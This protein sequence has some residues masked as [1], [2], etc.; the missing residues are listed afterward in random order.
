MHCV[1]CGRVMHKTKGSYQYTESGVDNVYLKGVTIYKCECG[2]ELPEIPHIEELHRVIAFEIV[3]SAVPLTG[4]ELRFLRKQMAIRAV[5]LA[6]LIGVDEVTVSR[7]EHDTKPVGSNNDRLIRFLFIKKVEEEL[8][9]LIGM[10]FLKSILI[11]LPHKTMKPKEAFE[12]PVFNISVNQLSKY[13]YN[14]ME[15]R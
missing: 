1:D 3:K 8:K 15:C 12:P 13:N 14:L 9:A 5:D 6:A 2:E 4:S 7:W 10:D 11:R